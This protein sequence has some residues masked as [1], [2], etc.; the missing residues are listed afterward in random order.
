MAV[1]L[2]L[3]SLML[4]TDASL[5]P[6]E[7]GANALATASAVATVSVSLAAAL[8]APA[9]VVVSAPAAIVLVWLPDAALVTLTVT[10]H[11][12]LAGMVAPESETLFALLTAVTTPPAQVVAPLAL[13][14]LVTVAG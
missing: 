3:L 9:L 10:V 13:T 8:L 11:E 4:S 7:A 6:T 5:V 2:G 1:A 14:V 12:P